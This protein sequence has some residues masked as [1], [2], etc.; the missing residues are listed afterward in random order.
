MSPQGVDAGDRT[1][2]VLGFFSV[3]RGNQFHIAQGDAPVR[4]GPGAVLFLGEMRFRCGLLPV[5]HR[6]EIS[7]P[8]GLKG[9]IVGGR[10]IG[11]WPSLH[12]G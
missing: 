4:S 2:H 12:H 7:K 5:T 9:E 11:V 6:D 1:Q 3:F 10:P 8:A